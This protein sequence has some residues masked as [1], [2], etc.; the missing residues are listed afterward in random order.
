[1]CAEKCGYGGGRIAIPVNLKT[2][3]TNAKNPGNLAGAK[4]RRACSLGQRSK[5]IRIHLFTE[6]NLLGNLTEQ[7]FSEMNSMEMLSMKKLLAIEIPIS[8]RH[9]GQQV[10]E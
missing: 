4:R 8:G 9:L 6:E 10:N 2:S 1:M 7:M 5:G 3:D